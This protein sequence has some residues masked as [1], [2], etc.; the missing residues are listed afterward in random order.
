M[1]TVKFIAV[2]F[3]KMLGWM[4]SFKMKNM[5]R[6]K[7]HSYETLISVKSAGYSI[8]Q[9]ESNVPASTRGYLRSCLLEND[10]F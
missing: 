1:L 10:K 2:L 5:K 9:I 3:K 4:D 6:C 8:R 7:E